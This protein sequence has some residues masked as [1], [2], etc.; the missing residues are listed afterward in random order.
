[1]EERP[2]DFLRPLSPDLGIASV[3]W[4]S[5]GV[6]KCLVDEV[7]ISE[8]SNCRCVVTFQLFMRSAGIDGSGEF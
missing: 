5:T 8:M 3:V 4:G 6:T 1:M 7:M 2:R